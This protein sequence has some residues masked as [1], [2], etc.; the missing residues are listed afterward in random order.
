VPLNPDTVL[1]IAKYGF[2]RDLSADSLSSAEF[3]GGYPSV[4]LIEEIQSR[5]SEA[6]LD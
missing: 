2:G 5:Q 3:L 1:S 6:G 4:T